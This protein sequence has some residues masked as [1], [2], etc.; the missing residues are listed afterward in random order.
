MSIVRNIPEQ[1]KWTDIENFEDFDIRRSAV[2]CLY[3]NTIGV[4]E[5]FVEWCPDDINDDNVYCAWVWSVR[6][7]LGEELK[8]HC[9]SELRELIESYESGG[10]DSWFENA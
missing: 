6:P 3:A 10:I 2:D 7:S 8:K 5:E 4:S 1:V 9:D